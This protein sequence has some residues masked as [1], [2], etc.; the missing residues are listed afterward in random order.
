MGSSSP[1]H[2]SSILGLGGPAYGLC[3][4][5]LYVDNF[6]LIERSSIAR[7]KDI[8]VGVFVRGMPGITV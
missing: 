6:C 8:R 7:E 4:K 2:A 3:S 5:K 1:L